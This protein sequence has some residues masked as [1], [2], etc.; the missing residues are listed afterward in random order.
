MAGHLS[1][2]RYVIFMSSSVD[3][4]LKIATRALFTSQAQDSPHR[5]DISQPGAT[6]QPAAAWIF[7]AS[8]RGSVSQLVSWD[9][10]LR[11]MEPNPSPN[12]KCQM[13]FIRTATRSTNAKN[14]RVKSFDICSLPHF[15]IPH[16]V[17]V[18]VDPEIVVQTPG[19]LLWCLLA[20]DS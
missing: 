19:Y 16:R 11:R 15:Q 5:Q 18:W 6:Y 2:K 12:P 20:L 9:G 3:D 1:P 13:L 10:W 4:C 17:T 8:K 7:M 14:V